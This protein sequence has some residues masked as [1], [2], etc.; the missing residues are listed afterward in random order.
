MKTGSVLLQL[1]IHGGF[2]VL[3]VI[4]RKEEKESFGQL[5]F[6]NLISFSQSPESKIAR[7]FHFVCGLQQNLKY[8]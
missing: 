4:K 8:V 1:E 3:K 7:H 2:K 5:Y 6:E